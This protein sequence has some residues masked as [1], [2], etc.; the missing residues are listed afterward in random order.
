MSSSSAFT[1]LCTA[2][3]KRASATMG[4]RL[5]GPGENSGQTS[6]PPISTREWRADWRSR[7]ADARE[8]GIE[9]LFPRPPC[10]RPPP[11]SSCRWPSRRFDH[12]VA[13][14]SSGTSA[15]RTSAGQTGDCRRQSPAPFGPPCPRPVLHLHHQRAHAAARP[16]STYAMGPPPA[17]TPSA[18]VVEPQGVRARR[19]SATTVHST[20]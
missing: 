17:G 15:A 13:S 14:G 11:C 18:P 16:A 6:P 10:S 9:N 2:A 5:R 3:G 8:H 12:H 20:I 1:T 19:P 7:A 4:A